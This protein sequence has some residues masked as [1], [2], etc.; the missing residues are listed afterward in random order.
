MAKQL[1]FKP[2][3]H[4]YDPDEMV[5]W[6]DRFEPA[7]VVEYYCWLRMSDY[8]EACKVQRDYE[9]GQDIV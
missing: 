2:P 9:K 3:V 6:I 4:V 5:W 7:H 1:V 8:D